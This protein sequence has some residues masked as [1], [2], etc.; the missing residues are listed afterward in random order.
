MPEHG[1]REDEAPPAIYLASPLGFDAPGRAFRE[2]TLL[3]ALRATGWRLL[4][5]WEESPASRQ[6]VQ[7]LAL[8][9]A[10]A[11]PALQAA[12]EAVGAHNVELLRESDAVLAWLDGVDL[13]SGTVAELGY[14]T[15][16]GTP[17]VGVRTDLRLAGD[18]PL[19][20]INLQVEHFLQLSGGRLC[21]SLEEGIAALAAILGGTRG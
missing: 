19:A 16:L 10:A 11:A 21:A 14:A 4:D 15:G 17:V 1:G 6:L 13:D 12:S 20:V 3:P 7:A 18:H 5:P 9:A 8:P 2:V